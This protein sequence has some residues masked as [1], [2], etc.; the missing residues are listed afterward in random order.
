M[1]KWKALIC[2][3]HGCQYKICVCPQPYVLLTFPTKLCE[4]ERRDQWIRLINRIDKDTGNLWQPKGDSRICSKHFVDG[5]PTDKNP[6]PSLYL[7]YDG[8]GVSRGVGNPKRSMPCIFPPA[9]RKKDGEESS[10]EAFLKHDHMYAFQCDC[11]PDCDCPGCAE[12]ETEVKKLRDQVTALR[13]KLRSRDQGTVLCEKKTANAKRPCE[14]CTSKNGTI[15]HL[16]QLLGK[17]VL[18]DKFCSEKRERRK[19]EKQRNRF[20]FDNVKLQKRVRKL[21]RRRSVL[22]EKSKQK[23]IEVQQR[24]ERKVKKLQQRL[25]NHVAVLKEYKAE[26]RR[27]LSISLKSDKQVHYCTGIKTK[28][29]FDTMF[30]VVEPHAKKINYWKSSKNV[31]PK[32]SEKECNESSLG[33][34]PKE[35]E[36]EC[37]Q[38]RQMS[39]RNEFL[40]VLMRLNLNLSIEFLSMIFGCAV[41]RV[42][43]IVTK[44]V[45]LLDS[46]LKGPMKL[47]FNSLRQPVIQVKPAKKKHNKDRTASRCSFERAYETD[48]Q[49]LETA[50]DTGETCKKETQ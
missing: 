18:H 22:E 23:C 29:A 12:K 13:E 19:M 43:E 33:K 36:K 34:E 45:P 11:S 41:G 35:S 48:F 7:G 49:Q 39:L 16:K 6:D 10:P 28:E 20:K 9:K 25:E 37:I 24:L 15:K 14:G 50:C 1:D 27:R 44:W 17:N 4:P 42:S 30:K 21:E 40:L 47:T 8:H 3:E 38:S 5:I 2:P 31:E 46:V 32:E 26:I